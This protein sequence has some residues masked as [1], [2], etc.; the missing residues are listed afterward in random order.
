M[1]ILAGVAHASRRI[2]RLPHLF[3]AVAQESLLVYF[4]H[5]CII[6]GSVWNSGLMQYVGDTLSPAQ[7]LPFVSALVIAMIL[8]A[9]YWNWYKHHRPRAARWVVA[10]VAIL[11]V[12]RLL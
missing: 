2:T 4:V 8:M 6:Y 1:V 11:M 10:V 3:G 12:G 9:W 5:L 7:T